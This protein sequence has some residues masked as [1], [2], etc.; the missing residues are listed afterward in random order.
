LTG[1]LEPWILPGASLLPKS[2][3]NLRPARL[4]SEAVEECRGRS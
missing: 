2:P 1:S 4:S 3:L